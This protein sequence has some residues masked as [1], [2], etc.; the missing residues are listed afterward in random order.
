MKKVVFVLMCLCVS[1]LTQA[2]AIVGS[3]TPAVGDGVQNLTG[4]VDDAGN[5]DIQYVGSE[6]L[7]GDNGAMG[8]VFTTNS[9][10]GGYTLDA[11][12][13]QQVSFGGTWWDYTGGSVQLQVFE[14]GTQNEWGVWSITA[15]LSQTNVVPGEPDGG[16]SNGVP[17]PAQW[18]TVTL[19]TSLHLD[20]MKQYGFQLGSDGTGGNDG[21]F[22]QL[23]G[24]KTDSYTG[25][26]ATNSG[27]NGVPETGAVWSGS[28]GLNP[29]DRVFVAAM[30][31]V[32]EPATMVL[33][34]LGGLVLR[35]KR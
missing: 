17:N 8:Q 22:M 10:A 23:N 25:G 1:S 18:L 27:G 15:L 26:F 19:D 16:P 33:L 20:A 21:F 9:N 35:R 30:T 12:S 13:V 14:L 32:P 6:Y 34:G 31:A 2:A 28:T 11:I 29:G 3:A 4:T 7:A 5:V 24:T